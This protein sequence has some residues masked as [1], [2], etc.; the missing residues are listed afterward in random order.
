VTVPVNT[1]ELPKALRGLVDQFIL[2]NPSVEYGGFILG[3]PLRFESFYPVPN[4]SNDPRREFHVPTDWEAFVDIFAEAI[5]KGVVGHFHTHPDHSIPSGQDI[6]A[7][8]YWFRKVTYMILIA[9]NKEGN[10]TTWWILDKN[11]EVQEIAETD[12][13]LEDASLLLARRY[14]FA[15]LGHVLMDSDGALRTTGEMARVLLA[16]GDARTLYARLVSNGKR[17]KRGEAAKIAGMS[18]DRARKA[19]NVL[20]GAGF[21][22]DE[23][24]NFTV[25]DIFGRKL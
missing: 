13:E 16:D 3:T 1:V 17:I 19:F 23:Y 20:H 12:R 9:P 4:R 25:I 22:K 14:G 2:R 15:D 7:G 21:L 11:H 24:Q 8:E 5:G 6:K 18:E 10:K